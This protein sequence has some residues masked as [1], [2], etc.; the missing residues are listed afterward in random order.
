MESLVGYLKCLVNDAEPGL[1]EP[2]AYQLMATM[3][4]GGMPDLE[5]GAA[6]SA[7]S[8]RGVRDEELFGFARAIRSRVNELTLPTGAPLPVVLPSYGGG[9]DLPNL[10]PLLAL[11]LRRFGIPVLI[12]GTLEGGDRIASAYVLRE[13]GIFPSPSVQ[14]AQAQ[15]AQDQLAFVPTAVLSPGVASL[16]ALR[17]RIGVK[18]LAILMAQIIDPFAGRG[19]RLIGAES[20]EHWR[21]IETLMTEDLSGALVLDATE[22][23]PFAN[24]LRRPRMVYFGDGPLQL[25]FE[26]ESE[27]VRALPS[28]PSHAEPAAIARWTRQALAH[29]VP[30]PFPIVNQLACCLYATGY[31]QDMNQAKAIAAVETGSLAAA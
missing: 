13:L 8:L 2:D 1:T 30:L 22:G 11:L 23:E 4:D 12:H 16:Y 26:R 29:E 20:P 21:L 9:R 25:M 18:G 19:V 24:P 5:L 31:T 7:L 17:N 28:L 14:A 6:L 3:L 15:L 27:S 10:T